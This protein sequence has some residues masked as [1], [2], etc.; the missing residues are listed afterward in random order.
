MLPQSRRVKEV[1][2]KGE[3]CVSLLLFPQSLPYQSLLPPLPLLPAFH[4]LPGPASIS[5][6]SSITG[7]EAPSSPHQAA[8][9]FN[10]HTGH[11]C[12]LCACS[13]AGSSQ[14]HVPLLSLPHTPPP[15]LQHTPRSRG[16]TR[17]TLCSSDFCR[18][19]CVGVSDL[20]ACST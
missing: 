15:G 20:P 5:P 2:K 1:K 13:P 10:V 18:A 14:V 19:V 11:T 9:E 7:Q 8:K 3:Q 16:R 17:L 4:A 12:V 6:E